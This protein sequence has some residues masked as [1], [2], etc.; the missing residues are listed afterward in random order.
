MCKKIFF[1]SHAECGHEDR[2]TMEPC[3]LAPGGVF[4]ESWGPLG[5]AACARKD[6]PSGDP[7]FDGRRE[8]RRGDPWCPACWGAIFDAIAAAFT[9]GFAAAAA[10]LAQQT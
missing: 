2:R 10:A 7:A 8:T 6:G 9:F 5:V 1:V 3:G 4:G